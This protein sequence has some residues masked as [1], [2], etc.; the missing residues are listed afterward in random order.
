MIFNAYLDGMLMDMDINGESH[1][2]A[3]IKI[4]IDGT[5]RGMQWDMMDIDGYKVG[6]R[7]FWGDIYFFM[8]SL[9]ISCN[10]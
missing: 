6:N 1:C 2:I 8:L 10:K 9:G 7:I 5:K 4:G 3:G